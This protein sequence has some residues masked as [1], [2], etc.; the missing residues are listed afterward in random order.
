MRCRRWSGVMGM[1]M[2]RSFVLVAAPCAIAATPPTTT[3]GSSASCRTMRSLSVCCL[4]GRRDMRINDGR[5]TMFVTRAGLVCPSEA[6]RIVCG[7]FPMCRLAEVYEKSPVFQGLHDTNR[8]EGKCGRCEFRHMCGGSRAHAYAKT[9]N[10]YAQD[11]V[12]RYVPVDN[13]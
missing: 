10:P 12:C 3:N 4:A 13:A 5:G 7:V 2:S 1:T 6:L 11:P 9:G 8:V